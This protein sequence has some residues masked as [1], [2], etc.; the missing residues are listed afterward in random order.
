[1]EQE[2]PEAKQPWVTCFLADILISYIEECTP[3]G[4]R[5]DYQ[6]LLENADGSRSTAIRGSS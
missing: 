4:R 3:G 6:H 1:M 2:V 5:I